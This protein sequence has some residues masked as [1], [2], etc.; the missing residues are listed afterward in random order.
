MYEIMFYAGTV[1]ACLFLIISIIL[2]I[3]NGVWKLIGDVT[4]LNARRAIKKL[5]K[6]GA[7]DTSKTEAIHQEVSKVLVHRATTTGSL[8][9]V[10]E[11]IE[12]DKVQR[13]GRKKAR[14]RHTKEEKT[15]LLQN[16]QE[17]AN[18]NDIFEVEDEMIIL[19]GDQK[20]S[21]AKENEAEGEYT[22]LLTPVG[23]ANVTDENTDEITTR[24]YAEDVATD[25]LSEDD[26][27]DV[28]YTEE[29]RQTALLTP[30]GD[31][32]QTTLLTPEGDDSQ[33]TLLTP[34][35]DD[36]Q[37]TLLTPEGDDGQTTLLTPEGDDSQTTLLTL[38]GDDSQ[39]TLLTM[40]GDNAQ[41]T[42]LTPEAEITPFEP[43][44]QEDEE[45]MSLLKDAV[46]KNQGRD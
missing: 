34:E 35:G 8:Q 38:E 28:L 5:D 37:T 23:S 19:A 15:T 20:D 26:V 13:S 33:T 25:V 4:G 39:T 46:A 3:K 31:D 10:T 7:E 2:F 45:L 29:D 16:T 14:K 17:Q 11:S 1:L 44:L 42:L 22:T 12:K 43:V 32:S 9:A 41:T 18:S 36:S 30:E 27:T 24:L 6:K 40:E 21:V